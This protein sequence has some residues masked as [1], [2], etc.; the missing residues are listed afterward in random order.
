MADEFDEVV[1]VGAEDITEVGAEPPVDATDPLREPPRVPTDP[2]VQPPRDANGASANEPDG[3][4][5][6]L[7]AL[8]SA[9]PLYRPVGV[10]PAA[11]T[12]AVV[13]TGFVA[14]AAAAALVRRR[15]ARRLTRSRADVLM[16]T[17]RQPEGLS[18]M[19]TRTYL[20][21]V[22]VLGRPSE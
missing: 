18:I 5:G 11:H 9:R 17:R 14:G 21:Q 8:A 19:S 4:S 6:G 1:E 12:A 2:V 7:P 20:V 16:G 13:A 10:L 3:D 22:H 15:S